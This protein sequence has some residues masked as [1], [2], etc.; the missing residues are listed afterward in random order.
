MIHPN[1]ATMLGFITCDCA[2]APDMLSKA[3]S[4]DVQSS[5]NMVTVDG[6]T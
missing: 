5:F 1:M 3:L 2:I 4:E 6:D